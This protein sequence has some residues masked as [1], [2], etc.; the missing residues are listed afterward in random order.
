MSVFPCEWCSR[1]VGCPCI[2]DPVEVRRATRVV[3][4]RHQDSVVE[5]KALEKPGRRAA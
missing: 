5:P 1:T 3:R 2:T 4:K